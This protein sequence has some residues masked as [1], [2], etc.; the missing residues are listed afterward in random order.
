MS[1]KEYKKIIE[2][3]S[4]GVFAYLVKN[5]QD[6]DSSKDILQDTFL[7][8]WNNKEKIEKD[9]FLFVREIS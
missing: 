1:E 6:R 7:S 2:L 3:Y 8:L 9:K 5:L 4:D